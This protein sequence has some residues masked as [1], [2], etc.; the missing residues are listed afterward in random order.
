MSL[1]KT[2][3]PAM[4]MAGLL[5]TVGAPVQAEEMCLGPGSTEVIQQQFHADASGSAELDSM[6]VDKNSVT[7]T[8]LFQGNA[9]PFS[10]HRQS[11]LP[12]AFTSTSQPP[13]ALTALMERF[14]QSLPASIWSSC[15]KSNGRESP[16]PRA[17]AHDLSNLPPEA[18]RPVPGHYCFDKYWTLPPRW[19]ITGALFAYWLH[20]LLFIGLF[21]A[22]MW[23]VARRPRA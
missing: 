22:G 6:M 8:V 20:V 18:C 4:L 1:G 21:G 9:Y 13:P 2:H 3:W 23:W 7:L 11:D 15:G 17:G 5:L 10:G 14:S 16:A 12:L 19:T